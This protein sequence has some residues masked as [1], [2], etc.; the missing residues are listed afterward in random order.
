[1]GGSGPNPERLEAALT[2]AAVVVVENLFSLPLNPA[3]TEA[4]TRALRHRPVIVRHHDLPWQLGMRSR[5]SWPPRDPAWR[6]ACTSELARN[7]LIEHGIKAYRIYN[8]FAA[9]SPTRERAVARSQLGVE[10]Q[11]TLLLQP[12]RVLARKQIDRSIAFAEELGAVLWV[13]GPMEQP[14][15]PAYDRLAREARCPLLRGLRNGMSM[16]DAY[17]AADAVV[18][19]SSW[20]G[21]G[22]PV[23]E[24]AIYRRPLAVSDYPVL[25]EL[26]RF[27]LRWFQVDRPQ[28]LRDWLSFPDARLLDN[29]A[30]IARRHFSLKTLPRAVKGVLDALGVAVKS[31]ALVAGGH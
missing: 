26:A 25:R 28:P 22:N 17:N 10:P 24:S 29:N 15:G 11:T 8:R 23:I 1:V 3:A 27:G 6:H 5:G 31:D 12:T 18:F 9:E 2:D 7:Q 13:T 30:Q 19:P 21:F 14:Y 4:L 16:S 20:E